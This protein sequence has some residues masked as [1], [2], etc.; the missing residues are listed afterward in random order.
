VPGELNMFSLASLIS[1]ELADLTDRVEEAAPFLGQ[2]LQAQ[3]CG[4]VW[5]P[6]WPLFLP[7]L[8][9]V[10]AR[11]A[12]RW[13]EAE[14]HLRSAD[15]VAVATGAAGE[16][17]R[18]RLDLAR[19][20]LQR[21]RRPVGAETEA[22][23]LL[24]DAIA[25]LDT[26]GMLPFLRRARLLLGVTTGEDPDEL[27]PVKERTILYSDLVDSTS[28]NVRAGDERWVEVL[29]EHNR[30]VRHCLRSHRG[31]EVKHTGDGFFAWFRE[32]SD[33]VA[34]ALE[35]LE[36]FERRNATA[37]ELPLVARMGV[38]TGRP[39]TDGGDLFGVSVAAAA[40][41]CG[42]ADPGE[43]RVTAEVAARCDATYI[44]DALPA[45]ELKGLPGPFALQ[46]VLGRRAARTVHR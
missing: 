23:T 41:I 5:S 31:V 34:C 2:I 3:R 18:V 12:G 26:L 7:R 11:G 35:I 13:D 36:E 17:A 9:S 40:R 39:V 1:V 32:P 33:A 28:L 45:V 16:V 24:R 43:I 20:L 27:A 10:A 4:V 8:L 30:I 42:S 22:V 19:L 37:P 25:R 29:R 21:P 38:T 44:F 15:E 14:S 6:G 46:S